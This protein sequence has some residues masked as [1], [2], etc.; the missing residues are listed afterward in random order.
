MTILATGYVVSGGAGSAVIPFLFIGF[1]VL[2]V[3]IR[4]IAGSSDDSRIRADVEGQG[5]KIRSINWAPFGTGWFGSKNER[6]YEVVYEDAQGK[7]HHA[8]CK[9]SMFSGVYWTEDTILDDR[10]IAGSSSSLDPRPTASAAELIA[11]NQR[12]KA[13]VERLKKS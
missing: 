1:I 3:V 6:I 11:E 2:A 12:L 5:G 9:T 13:E 7:V 8:Y 4:L 10:G